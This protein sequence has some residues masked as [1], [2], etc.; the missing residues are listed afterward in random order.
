[1]TPHQASTSVEIAVTSFHPGQR[2]IGGG[3]ALGRDDQG[4]LRRVLLNAE[5]LGRAPM[6]GEAWRFTGALVLHPVH[7]EQIAA[8]VALPLLP[9]GRGLVR[10]LATGARFAGIGW[11]SAAVLWDAFGEDLYGVLE[12]RDAEALAGVI[13]PQR[14]WAILEGFGLLADEVKVFAW[15]D[16]YGVS[17]RTAGAAAAL[18]GGGAVARIQ[19]DPYSLAI[20][21][22]WEQVDGRALRLGL[23]VDDERRLMAAV[24]E[25]GARRWHSA[26]TASPRDRIVSMVRTLL[27]P[28][29]GAAAAAF[30]LAVGTGRLIRTAPNVDLW[31]T[32][33]PYTME[34]TV[35]AA[36]R[37][38]G[39]RPASAPASDAV[40]AAIAEV[41]EEDG[42][43]FTTSQREAVR[44]AVSSP[45]SVIAGGAG[46]GKTSVVKA[47][48]RARPNPPHRIT[49]DDPFPRVALA[50]RAAHR[51][52]E[53]T[54]A[55]AMTIHRFL[56]RA[57][58]GAVGTSGLLVIDESSMVD[59]PTAYRIL[60]RVPVGVDICWVGDPGQLPP[61]GP[62]LVFH[63]LA[64]GPGVPRM[65]LD[66][67]HRQSSASG[68]PAASA[69]I[70]AGRWPNLPEFDAARPNAE[71][72]F[73]SRCDAMGTAATAMGVWEALAGPPP[74]RSDARALAALRDAD[75]Q[76]L[77]PTR[78]GPSGGKALS[79]G[80][81][82]RWMAEQPRIRN[83]GLGV[84]SRMLWVKNDYDRPTGR[85]GAGGEEIVATL[86]NG[87]LGVVR[88]PTPG[89]ALVDWDDGQRLEI[90]E[91][92]LRKVARGWA[93]SIHKAQGSAWRRVIIPVTGSRL[94]DRTLIYTAITRAR[95]T[96]VLVGDERLLRE[97][98][99]AP[100]S[101]GGR[102]GACAPGRAA[103]GRAATAAAGC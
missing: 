54:G 34:R 58:T 50:G 68:I 16:R 6:E 7:G 65:V 32:R 82:A 46:T 61:I 74:A 19:A 45:V 31:Q 76:M 36:L 79:E 18:W 98:V 15:L 9:H 48:V 92:D 89:G 39:L 17:P 10:F 63:R 25:A 14:A 71:G 70:R 103:M 81:E 30:D 21:E 42:Y 23:A 86:M 29:G 95:S 60:R 88:W 72:V 2:D 47:I 4:D 22:S 102:W 73:L 49:G 24:G 55:E 40:D 51:L 78:W 53:A 84:G 62:G 101:A 3:I 64:E 13:G 44:M 75:V 93:I 91:G 1:M 43:K 96:A 5:V 27:G 37:E 66:V 77:C 41:E 35:E 28:G 85:T 90:A 8:T 57:E 56:K 52:A 20:L 97:A 67:V 26:H 87:T 99:E 83:W 59:L 38:R 94:L 12:R 69:E 80:I 100:P 33:A 11:R